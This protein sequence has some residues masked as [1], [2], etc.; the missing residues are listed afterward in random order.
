MDEKTTQYVNA[1]IKTLTGQR[2]NALDT[3]VKL[4][5][6]LAVANAEIAELNAKIAKEADETKTEA[7]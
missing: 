7:E 4:Q 1:T 5:A 6:E 3:N 2:N